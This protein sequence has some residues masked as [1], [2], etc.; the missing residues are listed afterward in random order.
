[1]SCK[2]KDSEISSPSDIDLSSLSTV[3][4]IPWSLLPSFSPS[5]PLIPLSPFLPLLPLY[6]FWD[7]HTPLSPLSVPP[8][9][10]LFPSLPNS[11]LP[12]VCIE[13]CNTVQNSIKP[14]KKAVARRPCNQR[15]KDTFLV[16]PSSISLA[17]CLEKSRWRKSQH[18]RHLDGTS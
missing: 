14:C 6:S 4:S 15:V 9:S 12:L 2:I 11:F 13:P 7:K 3:S 8:S 18:S 1:M 17:W 10:L 16:L 5:S